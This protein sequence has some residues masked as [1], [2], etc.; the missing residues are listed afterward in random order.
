MRGSETLSPWFK[1]HPS[2]TPALQLGSTGPRQSLIQ[3][4]PGFTT[5]GVLALSL[6]NNGHLPHLRVT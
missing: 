3:G 2:I 6:P 1:V 4:L 5:Q